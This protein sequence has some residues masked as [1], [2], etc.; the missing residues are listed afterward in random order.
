MRTFGETLVPYLADN[1]HLFRPWGVTVNPSGNVYITEG[2]GH[3]MM[4]FAANGDFLMSIG[5]AGVWFANNTNRIPEPRGVAVDYGGNIW[6]VETGSNR[7]SKW[8]ATGKYVSQLGQ[9]SNQGSDN[10]GWFPGL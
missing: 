3:R 10:R 8:D 4:K 6:I 1:S 5:Q 2:S 7:V 9:T